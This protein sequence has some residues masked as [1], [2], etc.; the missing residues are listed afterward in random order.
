MDNPIQ[1]DVRMESS[2]KTKKPRAGRNSLF[3]Y[4]I[5][6]HEPLDRFASNFEWE[7]Q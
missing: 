5:I 7:R 3:G 4:L 1:N 6:N 2:L